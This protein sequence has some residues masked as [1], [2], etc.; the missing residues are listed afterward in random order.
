MGLFG[1]IGYEVSRRTRDIG[2]RMAL[3]ADPQQV[4]QDFLGQGL[5]LVVWEMVGGA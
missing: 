1:V 4:V 3:G 5:I 2:I